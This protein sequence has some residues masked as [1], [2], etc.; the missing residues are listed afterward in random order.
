MIWKWNTPI[1]AF[2]AALRAGIFAIREKRI[3]AHPSTVQAR[4][5]RC[6]VCPELDIQSMQCKA[7]TCFVRSK[8]L[9]AS[10]ECPEGFWKKEHSRPE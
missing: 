8:T 3:L 9:L 4:L 7:C 10:E 1:I 5:M 2:R 6:A